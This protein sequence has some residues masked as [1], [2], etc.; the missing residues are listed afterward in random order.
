[1]TVCS[2]ETKHISVIKNVFYTIFAISICLG[3]G[4]L[5]NNFLGGLPASLYGM[6]IYCLFLQLNLLN[7]RKINQTNQW[8]IRHMGICFVPAAVGVID[9]FDL[10]KN[11]GVAIVAIIFF[12]TFMLLTF[13]ALLAE[14]YLAPSANNSSKKSP[15]S[16]INS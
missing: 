15:P 16:A 14:K 1:M 3:L 11:H 8:I 12:T 2:K 6:M 5:I 7:P 13:I 4:K 9:H 10:I